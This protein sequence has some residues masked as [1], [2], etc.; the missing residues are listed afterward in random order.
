MT[1]EQVSQ[2]VDAVKGHGNQS[3]DN[4][5]HLKRFMERLQKEQHQFLKEQRAASDAAQRMASWAAVWSAVA[6]TAVA[7]TAIVQALP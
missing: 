1:D 6:A 3:A 2:V 4:L 5:I 7:V